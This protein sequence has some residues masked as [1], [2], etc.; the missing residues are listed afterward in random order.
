M[1]PV[2]P[3]AAISTAR[4]PTTGAQQYTL[5]Q[6]ARCTHRSRRCATSTPVTFSEGPNRFGYRTDDPEY[7]DFYKGT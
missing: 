7:P 3:H 5:D 1:Q 2:T 4:D 6:Q